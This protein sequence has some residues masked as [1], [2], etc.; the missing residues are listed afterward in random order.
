M[1]TIIVSRRHTVNHDIQELT[2]IPLQ[3]GAQWGSCRFPLQ[4]HFGR[5]RDA[6][7]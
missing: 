1:A 7:T 5:Y 6:L 4:P 2:L 3:L